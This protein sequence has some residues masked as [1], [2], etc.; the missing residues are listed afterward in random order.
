MSLKALPYQPVNFYG[1]FMY[2]CTCDPLDPPTLVGP[3]DGLSWMVQANACADA[4]QLIVQDFTDP[5][6]KGT[7]GFILFPGSACCST[8]NAGRTLTNSAFV[9]TVGDTYELRFT[10]S[11]IQGN[12]IVRFGGWE[13]VY[14]LP[15]TYAVPLTATT[16]QTL[17]FTLETDLSL[18]CV[19]GVGILEGNTTIEITFRDVDGTELQVIT[20][21]ANPEYFTFNADMLLVQL[22]GSALSFE[23]TCFVIEMDDCDGVTLT[24]QQFK[25]LDSTVCTI[26]L[27]ACNDG[28]PTYRVRVD[29]KLVKPRW[30]YEESAERHSNGRWSRNYIDMQRRMELRIGEQGEA[31]HP[32][33]AKLKL[34]RHFYVEQEEFYIP[35]EPYEPLYEDVFDGTGGTIYD[36]FPKQELNRAVICGPEESDGCPPPPNYWVQGTGPNTNYI[37][38]QLGELIRLAP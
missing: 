18:M 19:E 12:I 30:E 32:F 21:A 15:G 24:S 2:G 8:N 31:L 22:P 16:T 26:L 23:P 6:W 7:G 1:S 14:N 9:P 27:S 4:E 3:E 25:M 5:D 29:G 34:F 35:G 37:I 36:I 17:E 10:F 33:L 28:E 38:T 13:Q 11:S 20:F